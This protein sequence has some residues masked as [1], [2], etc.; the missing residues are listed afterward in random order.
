MYSSLDEELFFTQKVI[1][2]KK[3][4]NREL[5]LH[6]YFWT[7]T[8]IFPECVIV[9]K[10][11]IFFFVSNKDYFKSK[12]YHRE[13][14]QE[15]GKRKVLIIRMEKT[16]AKFLLSFFP[17]PYIHDIKLEIDEET[18]K[19]RINTYLLS[20]EERGI[21]IGRSGDY[22]KAI[23]EIFKEYVLFEEY[24]TFKKYYL[25]IEIKCENIFL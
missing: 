24:A 5:A 10:N 2:K 22:I 6:K 11:F 4:Q 16:L 9:I 15:T 25:P 21:A 3:Y 17:D 8:K 1:L 18:G 12:I 23:N 13:F 14:R 19:R 7:K 20:Y